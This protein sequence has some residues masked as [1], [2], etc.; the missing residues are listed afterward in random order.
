MEQASVFQLPKLGGYGRFGSK[1]SVP[2]ALQARSAC[3]SPAPGQLPLCGRLSPAGLG[4]LLLADPSAWGNLPCPGSLLSGVHA[5]LITSLYLGHVPPYVPPTVELVGANRLAS[6]TLAPH[7][8]T[9]SGRVSASISNSPN[10]GHA[11]N[12]SLDCCDG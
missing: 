11:P 12:H 6:F 1:V 3:H 2:I 9:L 4:L 7:P 5:I 10:P 8:G